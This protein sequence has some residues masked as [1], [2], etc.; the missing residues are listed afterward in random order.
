MYLI[1]KTNTLSV[2]LSL[3][4][5]LD[6]PLLQMDFKDVFLHLDLKEVYTRLP[7]GYPQEFTK[8]PIAS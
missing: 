6:L 3:V 2:L 4:G 1:A 8:G 7:L 5:N